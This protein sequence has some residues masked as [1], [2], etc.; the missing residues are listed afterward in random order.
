VIRRVSGI[1]VAVVFA[2]CLAGAQ[3]SPGNLVPTDQTQEHE[4]KRI[5]GIIPNYRTSPSL[6]NYEPLTTREKFKVASEDA[7]DRGTV[8]LAGFF[9]G[10]G[11]LTNSNRSFGQGAAGFG[12][13]FGTAYGDFVI[14]DYMTE[15]VFPTVFHQDPRYFRKG[16][17]SGWSRLGYAMGQIFWTHND[18]GRTQF[19]YSEIAGNSAAAAIST[20]Y[21]PDNRT[22]QDAASKLGMQLGVDMAANVLKEFWPEIQRKFRR[23]HR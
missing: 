20:A 21:Y 8:V 7:F 22:A 6:S 4:S 16:T 19:N 23:K 10:Y 18:S 11:Q 14:G 5:L 15:A 2:A 9:G 1:G 12:R 13:Y 3:E 17:G